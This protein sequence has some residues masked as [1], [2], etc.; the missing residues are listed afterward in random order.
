MGERYVGGV[1]ALR[2]E[3]TPDPR[4]IVARVERVPT[5]AEI[6]LDPRR[7]IIRRVGRW[8][9]D[10]GKIT[11]AIACRNVQAA[12]KSDGKMSVVAAHASALSVCFKC[13]SGWTGMFVT[14]CYVIMDE[15]AD[16]LHPRPTGPRV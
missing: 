2:D 8:K 13:R 14:E 11:G 7:K 12:A 5:A 6:D 16:S 1:A 10:I 3:D 15:V 9:A 4:G